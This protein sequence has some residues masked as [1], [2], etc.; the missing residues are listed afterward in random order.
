MQGGVEGTVTKLPFKESG[1]K[2]ITTT[3]DDQPEVGII[4]YQIN[5]TKET[6]K[7]TAKDCDSLNNFQLENKVK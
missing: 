4:S 7:F 6:A 3:D 1:G 2:K 5:G